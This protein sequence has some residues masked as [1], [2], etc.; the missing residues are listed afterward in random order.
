MAKRG[1]DHDEK[2]KW[3][4]K[5]W[6]GA[7]ALAST[8]PQS[9]FFSGFWAGR[10]S[11]RL[12]I[13]YPPHPPLLPKK[14]KKGRKN[15]THSLLW[16][17]DLNFRQNYYATRRR[18]K[19]RH[20]LVPKAN[21]ILAEEIECL[22]RTSF[23]CRFLASRPSRGMVRDML[24]VVVMENMPSIKTVRGLGKHFFHIELCDGTMAQP[25]VELKVLEL[26]YDKVLL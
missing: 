24:K 7:R 23:V 13:R 25:L 12:A 20:H 16:W 15:R 3:R 8:A 1:A 26:K 22:H 9:Q 11:F 18:N 14:N 17:E 2:R 10:R 4:A 5:A 6:Q 21:R 19:S